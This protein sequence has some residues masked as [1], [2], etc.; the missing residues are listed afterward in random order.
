M[1]NCTY[2]IKING[3][4]ML[5]NSSR[6]LDNFL[7]AHVDE[8][9]I[10]VLDA[11]LH[12]ISQDDVIQKIQEISNSVP[13]RGEKKQIISE[14]GDVEETIDLKG[15]MGTTSFITDIEDPSKPGHTL[16][17]KFDVEAWRNRQST[18]GITLHTIQR[19]EDS[20]KVQTD[21][22]TEV[23]ALW[24]S[25]VN[26][27]QF[28]RKLLSEQVE[29]SLRMQFNVLY[30][31]LRKKH[32]DDAQF[33]VEVP[34]VSKSINPAY[35]NI[36]LPDGSSLES[37]NGRID[38]LII[39]SSGVAHIYD[40]KTSI[41]DVGNWTD[42]H[43]L[44]SNTWHST[45]KL[46]AKYQLAIYAQILRQ[47][48][49][50]VG[51][52]GIIPIK[53]T[54]VYK[55]NEKIDIEGFSKATLDIRN[56]Q[57]RIIGSDNALYP[58]SIGTKVAGILPLTTFVDDIDLTK[59]IQEPMTKMF[60]NYELE[61]Q[62]QRS[63][64]NLEYLR[65]RESIV[66]T[67]SSTD[68][69]YEKG[70]FI[71]HDYNRNVHT[72]CNTEEEITEALQKLVDFENEQRA[73]E[74][75][76]LAQGLIDIQEGRSKFEDL[77]SSD[78]KASYVRNIFS[79]YIDNGWKFQNNPSYIAAGLFIFER[80]GLLEIVTLTQN[81]PHAIVNLGLGTTILGATKRNYEVDENQYIRAT[82]G[83]IDLIKVMNFLNSNPE[84]LQNYMVNSIV[85]RNIWTRS[86]TDMYSET[87]LHNFRTLCD[88]HGVQLNLEDKHFTT[89][90]QS[91]V[92]TIRELCGNHLVNTIGLWSLTFDINNVI[93]GTQ[94]I[95][96][97]IELL[98]SLPNGASEKLNNAIASGE[99]DFSDPVQYSYM[100]LHRALN[101]LN[102][103]NISVEPDVAPWIDTKGLLSA[104]A[105]LTSPGLSP[106]KI[107]QTLAQIKS[108][109]NHHI[110]EKIAAYEPRI[111]KVI[112]ALYNYKKR[113][114][115]LGDELNS[116]DNL[117]VRNANN[118]I[119]NTFRL[120]DPTDT[121]LSK[122]ESEFITMFLDIVNTLKFKGDP[123]R[124]EKAKLDG[125]YYEVPLAMASSSTL[126]HNNDVKTVVTE[127]VRED[128]NALRL[129]TEEEAYLTDSR[130]SGT[131][132]NRYRINSNTRQK[133]LT[134]YGT[135]HMETNLD[136]LLRSV[137]TSYVTEQVMSE[138]LPRIMGINIV[139]KYQQSMFGINYGNTLQFIEDYIKLNIY[140]QPIMDSKLNTTYKV[141]ATVRDIT[142]ST[143][144]AF[145]YRSGMR[146]LLQG[147]WIH[148]TRS[149]A[150][151]YGGNRITKKNLVKAWAFVFKE[152]LNN[153][154]SVTLLDLL[155]VHYQMANADIQQLQERLSTAKTGIKNF[156]SS[157]LFIFNQIPDIYHRMGI[158]ISIMMEDG[159][160][161]AHR[162]ENNKLIYDFSKDSRFNLLFKPNSDKSTK[163][164]REQHSLYTAMRE[165]FNKEGYNLA[166]GD[167]LPRAYTV[168]EATSIKSFSDM[169]FGHYDKDQQML[170]KH[171]F[172]G[173]F[174]LHFKTFLSAKLET[175]IL[176]PGTYNQGDW[177]IK[178]NNT[179]QM[180]V[181]IYSED[182][183]GNPSVRIGLVS[184]VQPN[185][186][187]EPYKEW[188]GRFME[189][190][191]W[192][193]LDYAKSIYKLD[194][195]EL[196][197]LWNN[198]TKRANL[199]LFLEDMIFASI[200]AWLL[201]V[202]MNDESRDPNVVTHFFELS[203][204]NALN[205]APFF[206]TMSG[207][208]GDLNPPMVNTMKNLFRQLSGVLTGDKNLFDA[209][210]NSFGALGDV[211]YFMNNIE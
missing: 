103:Y 162:V 209:A 203:T 138:Y 63:E 163:E 121:S 176:K 68:P 101:K 155:N 79:K 98:R 178:Y 65:H 32:G 54:P 139:L 126:L 169:C 39:D 74:L 5:F 33:L 111:R 21:F 66:S 91:T 131:T 143:A 48:G 137:I 149:M 211:K 116:F 168:K 78:A 182:S 89:T 59:S 166:E 150:D 61:L 132:H 144:L 38:L 195:K 201:G 109:A 164:Y 156:G 95:L 185:E 186:Y 27:T 170:A 30:D 140:N 208:F 114:L 106:S 73:N 104:G 146:E 120:K 50:K 51:T 56:G 148:I 191:L 133:M 13:V 29:T 14:D 34:I 16:V 64:A 15:S 88:I 75:A 55:N 154:N 31:T 188:E 77:Y 113:S 207:M 35:T 152:S 93:E 70:K 24:E 20:W 81:N 3:Q 67:V 36:K 184:D 122:E 58:V 167:A 110:T 49:I 71:V 141:F 118:E 53:L 174:M 147:V 115:L 153:P 100:L 204:Y 206:A 202:W 172:I 136:K 46:V 26:G 99:F 12:T 11:S 37:I 47:Y 127:K 128:L 179:G 177:K 19:I 62:V 129:F 190:I 125:T 112:E 44:S 180:Y 183:S 2:T 161:E 157:Q 4:K 189:G 18:N 60:P 41:K 200:F 84:L 145:N 97:K 123:N 210:V 158:L 107:I 199:I 90:L 151:A 52:T 165:Q 205:E 192:S 175:W 135:N 142:T 85:S 124:I 96:E 17:P 10:D 7:A 25:I 8:F 9:K 181:R 173:A 45:K 80:N 117:F 105:Y 198:P 197:N 171:K 119:A 94:W 92:H 69:N 6:E 160:W 196:K 134:K 194:Y 23:H 159:C 22:G 86:G 72:Y 193:V 43:N 187:Y 1:S 82:N 76:T 102:D 83:N 42:M 28:T 130:K 40:L 87:L 57:V 108:V